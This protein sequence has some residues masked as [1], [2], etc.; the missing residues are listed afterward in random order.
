MDLLDALIHHLLGCAPLLIGLARRLGRALGAHR[1]L[2]G[3]GGHLVDRRG[4][5][6]GLAALIGH[7][8]LR[9][10][11]LAGHRAH[12][13][14][15]LRGGT[16][17][18]AHQQMN[19]LDEAIEGGRQFAQLVAA[20]HWQALGQIAVT[21]GHVVQILLDLQQRAQDGVAHQYGE[22]GHQDQQQRRCDEHDHGQAVDTRLK[23]SAG[24]DYVTLD[25]I[26]VQRG[27]EH[28]V[29]LGQMLRIAHLGHQRIAARHGEAVVDEMAAVLPGLDQLANG[30]DAVRVTVIREAFA[31]ALARGP[32]EHSA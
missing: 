14:G 4:D 23:H 29:P 21:L 3:G 7:G 8:L 32:L 10:L 24:F 22:A 31:D 11:R 6:I 5:L 30:V 12:Q 25:V 20:G 16:G 1:H 13:P 28:Q 9:A 15:Q 19:L 18:L 26:Q 2:V 27:T 17:N